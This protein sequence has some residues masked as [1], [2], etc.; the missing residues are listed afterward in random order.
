M[1]ALP[2]GSDKKRIDRIIL[3]LPVLL[4]RKPAD[5]LSSQFQ[6]IEYVAFV[7]DD[8]CHEV[9]TSKRIKGSEFPV[10][11]SF[12]VYDEPKDRR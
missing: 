10:R 7:D 11:N 9:N 3:S 12:S 1:I 5:D 8:N 6:K 2:I 4:M